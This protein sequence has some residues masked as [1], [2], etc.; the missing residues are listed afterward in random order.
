MKKILWI[1]DGVGWGYDN[2][3]KA[4]EKALPEYHHIRIWRIFVKVSIEGKNG[5]VSEDVES[6]QKR[7]DDMNADIIVSM[8]PESEKFL[9]NK[10][11]GIMRLSGER[12]MNGWRR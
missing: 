2:L 10:Q 11:S 6:Y 1:V 8:N 7:I 9:T 3:S 12:S 5:F 4:V